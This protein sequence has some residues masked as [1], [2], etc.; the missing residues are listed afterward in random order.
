MKYEHLSLDE[1]LAKVDAKYSREEQN[2]IAFELVDSL[3][4]ST[5]DLEE[6]FDAMVYLA[7]YFSHGEWKEWLCDT[8]L[9]DEDE[10]YINCDCGD[11]RCENKWD[12]DLGS[13][14]DIYDVDDNCVGFIRG[15]LNDFTEEKLIEEVEYEMENHWSDAYLDDED[16]EEWDD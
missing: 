4:D 2:N 8:F 6:D 9:A 14:I 1:I 11:Y 12:C 10:V 7:E 16:N 5:D 13:I 15:N 3:M